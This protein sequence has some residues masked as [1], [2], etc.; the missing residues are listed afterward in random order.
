MANQGKIFK[1]ENDNARF[2]I[3]VLNAVMEQIAR[4][5]LSYLDLNT[6]IISM[7]MKIRCRNRNCSMCFLEGLDLPTFGILLIFFDISHSLYSLSFK[8]FIFIR[9][10]K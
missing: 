5:S 3:G 1:S 6:F 10:Y 2:A 7:S 8:Y 4:Y 9:I